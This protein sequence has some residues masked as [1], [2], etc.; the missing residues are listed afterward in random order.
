MAPQYADADSDEDYYVQPGGQGLGQRQGPGLGQRQ[1][2][3]PGPG[4]A[5]APR[6]ISQTPSPA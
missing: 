2:P 1:G 4:G 6:I 5:K 3:G